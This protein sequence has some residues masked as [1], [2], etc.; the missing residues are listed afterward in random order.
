MWQYPQAKSLVLVGLIPMFWNPAGK[1][2]NGRATEVEKG[3]LEAVQNGIVKNKFPISEKYM[4]KPL[5]KR[6]RMVYN[7][8]NT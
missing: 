4:Q 3:T 5:D 6:P 1:A 2:K 7:G 8:A